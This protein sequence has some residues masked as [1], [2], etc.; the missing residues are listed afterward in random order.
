[1]I[2]NICF[3]L[4]VHKALSEKTKPIP[5]A[6]LENNKFCVSVHFRCVDEKVSRELTLEDQLLVPCHHAWE[7]KSFHLILLCV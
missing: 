6:K 2:T 1:M 3:L 7:T 4:Q 5:G